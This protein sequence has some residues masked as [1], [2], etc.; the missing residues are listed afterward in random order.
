VIDEHGGPVGVSVTLLQSL[1]QC[2][3][4]AGCPCSGTGGTGGT[5]GVGGSTGGVGGS[6]GGVGGSTG[7]VGGSTGGVGGS[8]GGVGGS[9]GGSGGTTSTECTQ[10]TS[11]SCPEAQQCLQNTACRSGAVCAFTR[12]VSG[13]GFSVGCFLQCFDGD[14]N[15]AIRA[16]QAFRCVARQCGTDCALGGFR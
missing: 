3:A 14:V 2:V 12:C 5:G 9:T 13:S 8:T 1:A 15:L 7:G 16:F 4:D 10:C 6:T 11:Q